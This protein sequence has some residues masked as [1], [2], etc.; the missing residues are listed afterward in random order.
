MFTAVT[1]AA[2]P[3]PERGI[4]PST[5]HTQPSAASLT[6]LI[7]RWASGRLTTRVASVLPLASAADAHR[8]AEEGGLRGK[9]VLKP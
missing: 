1:D 5:V 2:Q 6:E 4:E 7:D 9:L 3:G 8:R